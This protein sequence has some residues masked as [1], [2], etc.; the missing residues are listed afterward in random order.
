M[1]KTLSLI[2][3]LFIAATA[4]LYY[5]PYAVL[6]NIKEAVNSRD[7][8]K[9]SNYIDSASL[10]NDL[11]EQ[12]KTMLANEMMNTPELKDN[13]FSIL[14]LG[15]AAPLIEQV[16][17]IYTS[18]NGIISL[19][20]GEN[21]IGDN[22]SGNLENKTDNNKTLDDIETGYDDTNTFF[23]KIKNPDGK[24]LKLIFKRDGLTNWKLSR[25]RLPAELL[26]KPSA[27]Q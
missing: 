20:S 16:T 15:F 1:K 4:Y 17:T 12:F 27:K 6:Q 7:A 2:I 9:L 10:K 14:A 26:S 21:P 18:P 3:A 23:V 5:T 22:Q 11:D 13:P 19:F 24:P 25:M 8:D